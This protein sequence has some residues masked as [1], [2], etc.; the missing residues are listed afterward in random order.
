MEVVGTL[1]DGGGCSAGMQ[2]EAD[3]LDLVQEAMLTADADRAGLASQ[4]PYCCLIAAVC[5]AAFH[6]IVWVSVSNC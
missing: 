1:P 5:L 4:V 2:K 6:A 3:E